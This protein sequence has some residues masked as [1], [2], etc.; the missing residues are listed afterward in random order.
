MPL[1]LPEPIAAY[2]AADKGD[3]DAVAQ[4][5]TEIAVVTDEEQSYRGRVAISRWRSEAAVKYHYTSEPVALEQDGDTFVVTGHLEGDFPGSPVDL[6]YR[7]VLDG[8][9]IS[10][11]EI[12]G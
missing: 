5:F 10:T 4:C 8:D 7:F 9:K 3:G 12:T 2:F 1:K 11:L 6:Q